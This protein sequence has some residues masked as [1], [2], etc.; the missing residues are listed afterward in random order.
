[1]DPLVRLNHADAPLVVPDG[2]ALRA[3]NTALDQAARADGAATWQ[4]PRVE[5][6][7]GAL[8]E[9]FEHRLL[10]GAGPGHDLG[11]D[12]GDGPDHRLGDDLG[13]ELGGRFRYHCVEVVRL[14][15]R[16]V[17]SS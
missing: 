12:L 11:H 8:V 14:L 6:W 1:M 17:H 13:A 16:A 7:Q 10:A 15:E 5:T 4:P 9:A 2:A 3:L